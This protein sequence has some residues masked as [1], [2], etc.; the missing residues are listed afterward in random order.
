VLVG[1]TVKVNSGPVLREFVL[2][3]LVGVSGE[4]RVRLTSWKTSSKD[5]M[6]SRGD[7]VHTA[8][9]SK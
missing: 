6:N 3:R 1:F 4:L 8:V 5:Q 7:I 2:A 9:P